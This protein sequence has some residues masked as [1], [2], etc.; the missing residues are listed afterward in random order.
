MTMRQVAGIGFD[1]RRWERCFAISI[2][3]VVVACR[4]ATDG[5]HRNPESTPSPE[6]P[7]ANTPS[8]TTPTGAIRA[9]APG[10]H[11]ETVQRADGRTLRYTISV[12]VDDA[13]TVGAPLIVMLH[14]GGE[15]AP[16]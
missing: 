7:A 11:S 1:T 8:S 14:Y 5:T 3:L 13:K 6:S 2:W 15:V 10:L 9:L 12:P 4:S 16:F